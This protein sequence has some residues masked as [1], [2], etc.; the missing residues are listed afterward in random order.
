MAPPDFDT[1]DLKA[2]A[3]ECR[4]IKTRDGS[5]AADATRKEAA[6]LYNEYLDLILLMERADILE[7]K[8][9]KLRK[10]LARFVSINKDL[11]SV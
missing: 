10:K 7:E 9:L 6:R 5:R 8:R 4:K 11:S 3:E 2:L 1:W